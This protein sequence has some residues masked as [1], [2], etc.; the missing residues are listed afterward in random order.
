MNAKDSSQV[1]LLRDLE[2]KQYDIWN[3]VRNVGPVDIMASPEDQNNLAEILQ[4]ENIQYSVM[5]ENVQTLID[6]STISKNQDTTWTGT[7]TIHLKICMDTLIFLKVV[8]VHI[9]LN[10]SLYLPW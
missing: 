8:A 6:Q 5:I 1:E 3:E 4:N 7:A 10:S 2:G 9:K